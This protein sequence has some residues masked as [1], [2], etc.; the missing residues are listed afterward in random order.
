MSARSND[1]KH[2]NNRPALP[3]F[4]DLYELTMAAGY[5]A[6]G[7]S[8]T[9]TFS[10]Y[11][12][13]A[14]LPR[15]FLVAAGLAPA[16]AELAD[17]RFRPEDIDYLA[18]TGI[19]PDDFLD[20]LPAVRFTGT[21]RALPEG[22]VFFPDEPLLEVT[23]PILEAQL[24]ETFVLNTLGLHTMLASKAAR[25]VLAADGRP[26]VD[27]ALRRTQ[28]QDA[29]MALARACH[30]V[31]FAGTSNVLA[32]KRYGIPVSG[33]MAHSFVTAFADEEAAFRAYA[34]VFP[35]SSVFLIDTYDTLAGARIA[36]RVGKDMAAR[37]HRLRGVR[38]DS[39]DMI[40]LS[41][42]VRAILDEAGLTEV[43][44]FAS[45]GFDEF[46]IADALAAGA[47]IDAFGVGTK[48]GVS[49]DMPFLD[50]VYK[51]VAFAGRPIRKRSPGKET[52]GG[53]KQVFRFADSTGRF[54]EDVLGT[55]DERVD[56][57]QPLLE[58]VM[59]E[60]RVCVASPSLEAIR[61]RCR[62][63]M[64]GLAD[65]YRRISAPAVYPVRVSRRLRALQQGLP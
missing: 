22:T 27:F 59:R 4:T 8:G 26:L 38:L 52:L 40:T 56:G 35:D 42:Q 25:C 55:A 48:A 13:G 34:E 47:T 60:G 10:V 41:R 9:A 58:T 50:I 16:L 19:F 51:M 49:A 7:V 23:A 18:Q 37:G 39:G 2:S 36:A 32:G 62:R 31:G 21:V 24:L 45:S 61:E 63:Q 43:K 14:G 54:V 57:G 6:H 33:T 1:A 15:S 5:L 29:G 3:L 12:R 44:I 11:V 64:A 28:G 53:E 65:R 46:K 20:Y 17:F 30:I